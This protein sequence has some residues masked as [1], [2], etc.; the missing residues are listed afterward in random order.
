MRNNK[1]V[2]VAEQDLALACVVETDAEADFFL[3]G[4]REAAQQADRASARAGRL[5]LQIRRAG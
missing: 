5:A 2:Q 1:I 3:K 4:M